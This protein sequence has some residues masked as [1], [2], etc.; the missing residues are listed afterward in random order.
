MGRSNR[1]GQP[2]TRRCPPIDPEHLQPHRGAARSVQ[3][4]PERLSRHHQRLQWLYRGCRLQSRHRPGI[5][6]RQSPGSRSDCRQLS[7]DG[8]GS[9]HQRGRAGLFGHGR[10]QFGWRE[11]NEWVHYPDDSSPLERHLGRGSG[12]IAPP[13]ALFST[14]SPSARVI[15]ISIAGSPAISDRADLIALPPGFSAAATPS[16]SSFGNSA[17]SDADQAALEHFLSNWNA[18]DDWLPQIAGSSRSE[19]YDSDAYF[20]NAAATGAPISTCSGTAR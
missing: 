19:A 15:F 9:V 12:S 4:V 13:S 17:N 20:H 11:C 14:E 18:G 7:G 2:G 5:A 10:Q 1:A 6:R 3:P 16:S 8:P